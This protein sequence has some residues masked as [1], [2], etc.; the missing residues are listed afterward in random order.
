[1]N[2]EILTNPG[3]TF[4]ILEVTTNQII[5]TFIRLCDAKKM[6]NHLNKGGCFDGNT[7][8][9]FLKKIKKS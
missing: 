4:S 1:M 8:N 5:Y 3:N 7:P 6:V 9:F 2:Y